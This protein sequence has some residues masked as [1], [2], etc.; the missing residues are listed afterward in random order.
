MSVAPRVFSA[1][2]RPLCVGIAFAIA[3]MCALL[4]FGA[5]TTPGTGVTE[6]VSQSGMS[7]MSDMSDMSEA[8][9]VAVVAPVVAA[10][11][12]DMGG[13]GAPTMASMCETPC[14]TDIGGACTIAAALA[15]A[16][17]SV[18]FLASRRDTFLGLFARVGGA[19]FFVSRRRQEPTP[20]AVLSLSRLCVLRV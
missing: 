9:V 10:M 20:W 3:L 1:S 13:D 4:G 5:S 19:L 2:T 12:T 18:L 8:S 15:V 7:V 17:L 11:T 6:M 14:V 16:A